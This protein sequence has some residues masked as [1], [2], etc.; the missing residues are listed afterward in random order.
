[1]GTWACPPLRLSDHCFPPHSL[2]AGL[3]QG[4]GYVEA[5]KRLNGLCCSSQASAWSRRS[6]KPT[7]CRAMGLGRA[8]CTTHVAQRRGEDRAERDAFNINICP[9]HPFKTPAFPVQGVNDASTVPCAG[10]CCGST[11]SCLART[12]FIKNTVDQKLIA[13]GS[14][15][16]Q[17][18]TFLESQASA[19]K[20][21]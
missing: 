3:C 9:C 16:Q 21:R 4:L 20:D 14:K 1:M 2:S 19:R 12:A 15:I 6:R 7:Q 8:L 11:S 5:A 13:H 18:W 17:S 10:V